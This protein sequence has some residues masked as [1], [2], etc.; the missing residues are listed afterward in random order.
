[1]LIPT[2]QSN[3]WKILLNPG[4]VAQDHTSS[5]P[6]NPMCVTIL[7]TGWLKICVGLKRL[8]RATSFSPLKKSCAFFVQ[9]DY[10]ILRLFYCFIFRFL[11]ANHSL[12]II[13]TIMYIAIF[14][15][16]IMN[17][18]DKCYVI[19]SLREF[20]DKYISNITVVSYLI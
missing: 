2:I 4:L 18:G 9:S 5:V 6:Q 13:C 17:I 11:F 14:E 16:M 15:S 1:M 8:V 19:C 7:C 20:W 3:P 12:D 10:Y